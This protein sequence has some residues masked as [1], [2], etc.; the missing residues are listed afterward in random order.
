MT[1]HCTTP[2]DTCHV[3]YT[4]D[5]MSQHFAQLYLVPTVINQHHGQTLLSLL[6]LICRRKVPDE[7]L[8]HFGVRDTKLSQR[9]L[10]II[11]IWSDELASNQN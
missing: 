10:H 6:N 11:S 5:L 9:V 7:L 3:E 8:R 4:T 2:K 1:P